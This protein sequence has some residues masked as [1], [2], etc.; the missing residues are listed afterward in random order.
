M[1]KRAKARLAKHGGA[2]VFVGFMAWLYISLRDFAGAN[3][4][5]KCR[6]LSDAFT[7]PG[8][9]LLMFGCLIWFSNGGVLDGLVY[10]ARLAIRSLIPGGRYRDEKYADYVERRR[11]SRVKGYGF[12][13]LSG[14]AAMAAAIVFIILFYTLY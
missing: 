6:I 8:M 3:L 14:G 5:D 9:L 1:S 10:G 2:A 12:L 4:A 13:F 11:Q 7:V